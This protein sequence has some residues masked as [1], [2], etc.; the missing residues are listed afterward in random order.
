MRNRKPADQPID[1]GRAHAPSQA[2]SRERGLLSLVLLCSAALSVFGLVR[3]A[4]SNS[5]AG[6]ATLHQAVRE[7]ATKAPSSLHPAAGLHFPDEAEGGYTA[8]IVAQPADCDGNLGVLGVLDRKSIAARVPHRLLLVEGSARD[9]VGLR[10]RL[11]M[12]LQRAR[13]ALLSE[14]QRTVLRQLG[15]VATPTLLLFNREHQL[16][17]AGP[18]PPGPVERTVQLSV[19][20]RLVTNH[21]APASP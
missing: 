21:P 3:R 17:Y 13:M 11:P 1:G 18:T 19:I 4:E 10:Q 8:V 15:H 7:L 9:T 20:T 5:A 6:G 16:R 12:S 14:A 2:T